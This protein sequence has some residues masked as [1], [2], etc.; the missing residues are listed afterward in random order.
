MSSPIYQLVINRVV[1]RP[2]R[3][4]PSILWVFRCGNT[5]LLTDRLFDVVKFIIL[6]PLSLL[7]W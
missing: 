5:V 3:R 2:V 6:T 1:S 4:G 7:F